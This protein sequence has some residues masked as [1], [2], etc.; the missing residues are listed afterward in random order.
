MKPLLMLLMTACAAATTATGQVTLQL[1]SSPVTPGTPF[2]VVLTNNTNQCVDTLVTNVLTLMQPGGEVIAPV[3]VGCGPVATCLSNGQSASLTFTTPASGPGSAG[4]FV[5]L[6]PYAGGA[7]ARLDVGAPATGF[8]DLHTY[9]AAMPH[10]PGA[11]KI[12]LPLGGSPDWEFAN[13]SGQGRTIFPL[14]EVLLPGAAT[15]VAVSNPTVTVPA[16]GTT[17]VTT[18][19]AGLAPGPYT[20]RVTWLDPGIGG[21]LTASHGVVLTGG[22]SLDL[23]L[24]GGRVVPAGGALPARLAVDQGVPFVSAPV[25]S[26]VLAVGATPGSTALPGGILA[27]LAAADPLVQAS[28]LNGINGLLAGHAGTTSSQSVYCAHGTTQFAVAGGILLGHPN[29]PALSGAT[30]RIAAV[31]FEPVTGAWLASQPEQITLQ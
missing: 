19:F 21:Q 24:P 6:C 16:N 2:T 20:V 30:F 14:I 8:P 9:P 17:Q 10:G 13:T 4:S 31:A 1:P 26:Y 12:G 18:P 3:L 28:I 22:T 23:H 15:P 7:A 5:L 11:H 27:P 29:L 25:W